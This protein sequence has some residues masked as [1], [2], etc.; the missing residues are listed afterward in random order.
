MT[1][2]IFLCSKFIS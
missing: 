1:S 2:I